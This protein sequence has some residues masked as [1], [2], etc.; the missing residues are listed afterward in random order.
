MPG[1]VVD[2]SASAVEVVFSAESLDECSAVVAVALCVGVVVLIWLD[3]HFHFVTLSE[4][5]LWALMNVPHGVG[6]CVEVFG[7]ACLNVVVVFGG[8]NQ[9][10]AFGAVDVVVGPFWCGPFALVFELFV[11]AVPVVVVD[12]D[13]VAV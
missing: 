12:V 7:V 13:E 5:A 1:A 10:V 2:R 9:F 11:G 4:R 8:V 6:V 3:S